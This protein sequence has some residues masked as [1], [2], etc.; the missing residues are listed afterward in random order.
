MNTNAMI[1]F[2]VVRVKGS[3]TKLQKAIDKFQAPGNS[4]FGPFGFHLF[5]G[6]LQDR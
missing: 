5:L 2:S 6:C 1:P 3:S 4:G